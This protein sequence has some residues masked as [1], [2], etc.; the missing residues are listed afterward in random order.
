MRKRGPSLTA[1]GRSVSR[2]LVMGRSLLLRR[3]VRLARFDSL[4]ARREHGKASAQVLELLLLAI[5]DVAQLLIR[6][7]EIRQL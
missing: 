5:N 2:L 3:V 1:I 7:L 4:N 6:L